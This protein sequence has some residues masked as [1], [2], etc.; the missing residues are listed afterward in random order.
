MRVSSSPKPRFTR[1]QYQKALEIDLLSF[2]RSRGYEFKKCGSEYHM[3]GHDSFV[4]KGMLWRW[5]SRDI[6]GNIVSYLTKIEGMDTVQAVLYLCGEKYDAERSVTQSLKRNSSNERISKTIILPYR[7][8]DA[9]RA[10]AYLMKTRFIDKDIIS[11]MMK[12]GN[13]YE[14]LEYFVKVRID[15]NSTKTVKLLDYALFDKYKSAGVVEKETTSASSIRFGYDTEGDLRCVGIERLDDIHRN[16]LLKN[17]NIEKITSVNNCVFCG[18]N[19][20]GEIRYA[21][22]RGVTQ[23]SAYKQDIVGS[24]KKYGFAIQGES[25]EV[26]VFEAPIDVLS[27]ATLY[28]LMN[29]DW[30]KDSRVSL[31][32]VSD[33]AL[34]QYLSA[35]P[36][37]KRI[38][39][40]L[41]N[42]KAGMET[43]YGK[44][45]IETG[46][47]TGGLYQKYQKRGYEVS[48]N[49]PIT[50][51]YNQDL[52]EFQNSHESDEELEF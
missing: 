6:G 8:S 50:K 51:D 5:C 15:K 4:V 34:E 41:D 38:T 2:L 47:L 45:D 17:E 36:N 25:D 9:R 49:F 18:F 29:Y 33:L 30:Q 12:N 21:S 39:F 22:A 16:L 46:E 23:G 26:F 52:T 27:H 24:D 19:E 3:K 7:N 14:S 44:R 40:C 37:I 43:V 42:D 32:G 10:F 1:E 11:S 31:G 28:K 13:I 20:K 35:H 48:I